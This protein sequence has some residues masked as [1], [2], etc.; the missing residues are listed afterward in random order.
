MRWSELNSRQF[1]KLARE[2]LCVLPIGAI[3]QHGPHLPVATD[4]LIATALAE[5]LDGACSEKLLV[6]PGLAVTCSA[7]HLAFAGTLSI[8]HDAFLTLIS[9]VIESAAKHGFRRFFLLNAHG[10]NIAVGGVAAEQL[11]AKLPECD[12]VFATW[13]RAAAERLRPLVEGEFPAV[14]HACEFETSL[15][16]AL[17]PELVD[18]AAIVDDGIP[19]QSSLLRADLLSGASSVRSLPFEKITKHGV[20]GKPSLATGEKGQAILDI[21]V[22][23]L[24]DL[25]V[26]YWP[27]APGLATTARTEFSGRDAS[28]GV[29]P[30]NK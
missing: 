21:V 23:T 10:G 29:A 11:A 3:E 24:K 17:R 15:I 1:T 9:H 19:P 25:L 20:F 8:E 7:H 18:H 5:R 26:A 12:V 4:Y 16:L 14:G 28:N 13:F 2:T 30:R 22:P 6:M 27:D